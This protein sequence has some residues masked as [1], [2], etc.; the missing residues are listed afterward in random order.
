MSK[1]TPGFL[2]DLCVLCVEN[3]ARPG[4]KLLTQRA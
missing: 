3:I 4:E 1:A 2:R